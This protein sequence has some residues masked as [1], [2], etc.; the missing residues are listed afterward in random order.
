MEESKNR[1]HFLRDAGTINL[2]HFMQQLC[3][4]LFV[5]VGELDSVISHA[6][7]KAVQN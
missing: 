2:M 6:A 4:F 7:R 3:N 1:S 5:F